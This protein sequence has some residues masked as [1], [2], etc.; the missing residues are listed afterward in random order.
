MRNSDFSLFL[1]ELISLFLLFYFLFCVRLACNM[2]DIVLCFE[3]L[4][5]LI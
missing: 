4:R 5:V 2:H 3:S 1:I